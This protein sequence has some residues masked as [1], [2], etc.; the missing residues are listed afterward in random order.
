MYVSSSTNIFENLALE[1]WLYEN[2][3]LS[4]TDCLLMWRNAPAVVIGRHQNPWLEC[5]VQEAVKRNICVARRSSGGGTVYHDEGDGHSWCV[6]VWGGG[7]GCI[8]MK[9]MAIAGV[10]GGGVS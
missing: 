6:C 9:V 1:E 7:G 10:C 2:L 8:M 4:K 3:D 5:D